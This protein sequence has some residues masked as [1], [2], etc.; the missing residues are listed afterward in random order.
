MVKAALFNVQFLNRFLAKGGMKFSVVS[1]E[2]SD[3]IEFERLDNGHFIFVMFR[4]KSTHFETL[5]I[6]WSWSWRRDGLRSAVQCSQ[7][8]M[9]RIE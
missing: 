3:L 6:S 9:D 8:G 5:V 7:T 1:Q 4:K 2:L